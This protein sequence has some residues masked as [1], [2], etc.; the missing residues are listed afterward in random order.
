MKRLIGLS[1]LLGLIGIIA[2]TALAIPPKQENLLQL[3]VQQIRQDTELLGDLV[4]GGGE[5]PET[6]TGNTDLGSPNVLADLWFDHEQLA[7]AVF[8]Q[9]VRP[10]GWIGATTSNPTLVARNIRHDIEL[11]ADELIGD[12]R[13]DDWQGTDRLVRCSRDILNTVY[14]L[15]TY[16]DEQ[17]DTSTSVLDY[18]QALRIELETD[19]PTFIG[20]REDVVQSLPSLILAVRGD[21]ERLANEVYG[22]DSRPDGWIDNTDINSPTLAV[23]NNNDIELLADDI[24][25][26][27]QRPVGYSPGIVR[28]S[29]LTYRNLRNN[30]ELLADAYLGEGDRPRGWQGT[31][32]LLRCEA[33]IQNLVFLT[34]S[35][36]PTFDIPDPDRPDL[37]IDAYCRLVADQTSSFVEDPILPEDIEAIQEE[38]D[39]F[40]GESELAFT[41]LDPAATQYM[42]VMPAGTEFKAW[43]RNYAD[44]SMMFVSGADFAVFIDRRWTTMPQSTFRLLP[45][46][47]GVRP[48]TFCDAFWCNGPGPTPT[49]TG[50]GP[51][52]DIIVD[53][54][55]AATVA[56][57]EVQDE[58]KIL[59]SWNH[60]RVNY[61]LQ[62]PEVGAAQ[63]TLEICREV[64]QVACEPVIAV[65]DNEAG[66]PLPVVDSFNGLNVYELPYGYSSTLI[67][68]GEN[69]FSTDIW[70]NDPALSGDG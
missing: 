5:R 59:V 25:G 42:G 49:P 50:Q 58:G 63:V 48:L 44:S 15:Q 43:Y 26:E 51:L 56:P 10:E 68:E 40:L 23:D 21:I 64:A 53:A 18:C 52:L 4:F 57:V 39:R 8:G 9:G 19:V 54:T 36:F 3:S 62:R 27:G 41:Y 17:P 24:I 60:I 7:D 1:V 20:S 29:P 70:L 2:A 31:N 33:T 35:S 47:D 11:I 38:D 28:S 22:V 16:F 61:L 46:L 67:I 66:R 12:N 30:L 14:L 69:L 34:D 45:T 13:P 6:W 32:N 37:D 65:L 55:P